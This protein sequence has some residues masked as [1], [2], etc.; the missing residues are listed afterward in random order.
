M[1]TED[2]QEWKSKLRMLEL[3][4]TGG[5]LF[6]ELFVS[7]EKRT[8]LESL[9]CVRLHVKS[10][11]VSLG[12]WHV[13]HERELAA[14]KCLPKKDHDPKSDTHFLA[15]VMRV[16]LCTSIDGFFD[17]PTLVLSAEGVPEFAPLMHSN[18]SV[19]EALFSQTRSLNQDT[20]QEPGR[21]AHPRGSGLRGQQ[22]ALLCRHAVGEVKAV[23]P[24]EVLLLQK[25][26]QLAFS[27]DPCI[28]GH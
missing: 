15:K 3:L 11:L 7:R 6:N 12:C 2:L 21:S 25:T 22:S 14:N 13:E 5:A 17:C 20:S 4:V 1:P 9:G 26:A 24:M 19:L 10:P 23:A 8:T 16:N 18:S 27:V 28:K